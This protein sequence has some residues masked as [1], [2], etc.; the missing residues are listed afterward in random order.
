MRLDRETIKAIQEEITLIFTEFKNTPK[1]EACFNCDD[2]DLYQENLEYRW[3]KDEQ[4]NRLN[5]LKEQLNEPK[6]Y[7]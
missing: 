4:Q 7:L 3:Y 2:M 1:P 6:I 5:E